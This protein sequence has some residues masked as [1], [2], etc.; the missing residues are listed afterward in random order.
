M[1]TGNVTIERRGHVMM[2]GLDRVAKRNAFDVAMYEALGRAYGALERD[3]GARVGLL[4]AHGD[5]FTA[6]LDLAEFSAVMASG[7]FPI[8][9]DAIDPVGLSG[10]PRTKPLVCAISGICFTIGIELLLATDIRVATEDTRF[11]QIE[12]KRGIYPVCG[13]TIRMPR[14]V[15]WGNAMRWLLTGDELDAREAHRIGLVQEVTARGAAFPRALELAEKIALQA[16]LGVRA[17]IASARIALAE[18]ESVAAR[19]LLPDLAPILA[20]DDAREGVA[21]FVE[22]RAAR[23][24]GR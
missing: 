16:P 5:H 12:I 14:E 2:I 4:F 11:G 6:G 3:D 24:T 22:R 20:S 13:A 15:G 19:R 1:T 21:S 23:F 18:A 7:S 8:P 10:A 17:T 9:E